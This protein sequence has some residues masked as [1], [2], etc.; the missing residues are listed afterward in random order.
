MRRQHFASE[1][2]SPD[3]S[4]ARKSWR[5]ERG[6]SAASVSCG[7]GALIEL[8]NEL[9]RE[10]RPPQPLS[11]WSSTRESPRSP[12]A[13]YAK[14]SSPLGGGQGRAPARRDAARP[15]IGSRAAAYFRSR[16]ADWESAGRPCATGRGSSAGSR[17]QIARAG[18]RFIASA[19]S[20]A[21]ADSPGGKCRRIGNFCRGARVT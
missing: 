1:R 19:A 9:R 7:F 5:C 21:P 14:M 2:N 10:K 16:P 13:G 4:A 17:R 8:S 3:R 18:T 15:I 11:V 20:P 6:R 12:R